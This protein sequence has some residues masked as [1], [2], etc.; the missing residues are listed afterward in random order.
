MP[1]N[2]HVTFSRSEANSGAVLSVID[3]VANV[4]AVFDTKKG[5]PLPATW[6]GRKVIDGDI[7]DIRFWDETNVIVGLRAKGSMGKADESGFVIST[8]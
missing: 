4:A 6:A 8:K 1:V 2:Y 3:T 5:Q 7:T